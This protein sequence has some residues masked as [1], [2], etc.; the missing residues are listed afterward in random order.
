[1]AEDGLG[2]AGEH[3]SQPMASEAQPDV[4][5]RVDTAMKPMQVAFG[6]EAGDGVPRVS[7]VDQLP[8]RHNSMLARGEF[9]QTWGV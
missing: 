6:N 5:D 4:A 2:A 7:E 3:G 8:D 9:G 1:M